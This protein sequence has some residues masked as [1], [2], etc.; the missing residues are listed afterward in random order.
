LIEKYNKQTQVDLETSSNELRNE[1]VI[2]ILTAVDKIKY[3]LKQVRQ[4]MP[5]LYLFTNDEIWDV[6][7]KDVF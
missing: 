6:Y 5:P 3:Y 2:S 4:S 7:W 1:R